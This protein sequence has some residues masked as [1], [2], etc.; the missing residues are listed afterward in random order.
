MPGSKGLRG[1]AHTVSRGTKFL[2]G[3]ILEAS[4]P[5]SITQRKGSR[6]NGFRSEKQI[7]FLKNALVLMIRGVIHNLAVERL[8]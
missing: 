2:G 3:K 6:R 1:R 7:G 4:C 5:P 8:S